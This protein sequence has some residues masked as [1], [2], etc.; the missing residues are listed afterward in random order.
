MYHI[1]SFNEYLW[2]TCYGSATVL[3]SRNKKI[4]TV[5]SCPQG[6]LVCQSRQIFKETDLFKS[7]DRGE[8]IPGAP[9]IQEGDGVT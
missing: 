5:Q 1:H 2:N 8:F 3:V 9:V 4:N 6:A 7:Q